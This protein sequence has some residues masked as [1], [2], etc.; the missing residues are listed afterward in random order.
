MIK[1][2]VFEIERERDRRT[3]RQMNRKTVKQINNRES[4]FRPFPGGVVIRS[5]SRLEVTDNRRI[6]TPIK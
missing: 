3:A 4:G 2:R 5:P 6:V 1:A